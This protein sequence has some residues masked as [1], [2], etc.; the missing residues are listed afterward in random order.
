ML[1]PA[2]KY[3]QITMFGEWMPHDALF[4]M[5]NF[6]PIRTRDIVID[7]RNQR[8]IVKQI[9]K[10]EKLGYVIEYN[11]QCS[12][13]SHDDQIYELEKD[14][15]QIALAVLQT[16]VVQAAEQQTVYAVVK[17]LLD[18]YWYESSQG[19]TALAV[20]WVSSLK[21]IIGTFTTTTTATI[22]NYNMP[23]MFHSYGSAINLSMWSVFINRLVATK[24]T[25]TSIANSGSNI[26]ITFNSNLLYDLEA[27]DEIELWGPMDAV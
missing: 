14:T 23:A 9:R 12:L 7:D 11:A 4:T 22:E 10:T 1:N 21:R 25:I 2:P 27:G 17:Q 16:D 20:Q 15:L 6:P 5:L 18:S 19:D 13:I 8:W 3:N 26:V 24:Q